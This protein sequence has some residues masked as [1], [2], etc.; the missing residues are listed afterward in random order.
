MVARTKMLVKTLFA[1]LFVFG[2]TLLSTGCPIVKPIE[3]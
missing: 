3:H 1:V 2:L